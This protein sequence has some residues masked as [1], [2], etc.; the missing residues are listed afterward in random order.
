MYAKSFPA[1]MISLFQE[2]NK[3]VSDVMQLYLRVQCNFLN[4]VFQKKNPVEMVKIARVGGYPYCT[5]TPPTVL[6][7]GSCFFWQI[8]C[9][10]SRGVHIARF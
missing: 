5:V 8:N 9:I 2:G 3:T 10:Y 4:W 7:I 6:K 1:R